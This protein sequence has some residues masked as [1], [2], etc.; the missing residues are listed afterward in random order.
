MTAAGLP[1]KRDV[2]RALVAAGLSGRQAKKLLA[3][4]W[5]AIGSPQDDEVERLAEVAEELA[6]RLRERG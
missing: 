4:G 1:S 3:R 5:R 2:E 6:R